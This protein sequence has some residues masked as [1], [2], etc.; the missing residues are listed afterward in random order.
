MARKIKALARRGNRCLRS[1]QSPL[2]SDVCAGQAIAAGRQ[3]PHRRPHRSFSLY[4]DRGEGSY[5]YDIDGHRLIDFVN[6]NT[7][8]PLGHAHPAIVAAL[9]E[10]I[11]RGTGFSRPLALE[12]EMAELLRARMPRAGESALL[13]L[14]HR[15]RAQRPARGAG[16]Y[17]AHQNR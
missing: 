3:H 12:V 17:R 2:A 11:V 13:L 9:Q 14:G 8:L 16:A 6:N 5:L 1:A 4:A 15:G 10:Q 7:A